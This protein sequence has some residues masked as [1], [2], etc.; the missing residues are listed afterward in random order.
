MASNNNPYF[1]ITILINHNNNIMPKLPT[2]LK[3]SPPEITN[4]AAFYQ[5]KLLW[6]QKLSLF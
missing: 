6:K 1:K 4:F 3:K 2:R 5:I